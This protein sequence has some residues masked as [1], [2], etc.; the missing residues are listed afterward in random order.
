MSSRLFIAI[1]I[2][3]ET[4]S[5]I[6]SLQ[7]EYPDINVRWLYGH[8]LHITLIP[9]WYEDDT[10]KVKSVLKT[11]ENKIGGFNVKFSKITYGPPR[12]F[13]MIW[14]TGTLTKEI[15]N[16]KSSLQDLLIKEKII[17][18]PENR[19]FLLH[20]TLA[21]FHSEDYKFFGTKILNKNIS[22]EIKISSIVLMQ[23]H[24]TRTHAEYKILEEINL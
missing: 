21:R 11:L 7:R 14:A 10:E 9:P 19:P 1:K 13:R 5:K 23:S 17:K 6:L 2:S 12:D 8:N 3:E 22:W 4:K 16:L 20:L 18:I 24:L 15:I